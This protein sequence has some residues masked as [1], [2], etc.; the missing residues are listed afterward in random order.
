MYI[1]IFITEDNDNV[2]NNVINN[3]IVCLDDDSPNAYH[4]KLYSNA[5]VLELCEFQ[6]QSTDSGYQ[7]PWYWLCRIGKFLSYL[8][9]DF[10]YLCHVNVKE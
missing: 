2:I 7:H 3:V 8:R 5:S 9:K 4:S 6:G 1:Y 10:N